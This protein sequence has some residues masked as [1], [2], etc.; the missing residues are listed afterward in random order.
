MD[1]KVRGAAGRLMHDRADVNIEGGNIA[2]N[3]AIVC[4]KFIPNTD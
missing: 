2:V 1:V 4:R 3:V